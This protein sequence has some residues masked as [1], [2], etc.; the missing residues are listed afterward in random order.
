MYIIALKRE[1]KGDESEEL[2]HGQN[3]DSFPKA[4]VYRFQF[5]ETS[6]FVI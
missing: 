3:A 6:Y 5:T 4:E 2:M 1:I